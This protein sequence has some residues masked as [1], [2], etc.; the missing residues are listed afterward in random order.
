[1][2]LIAENVSALAAKL[3]TEPDIITKFL[4]NAEAAADIKPF[5]DSLGTLQVFTPD[6]FTQRLA[7]ERQAAATEATNTTLGKTYGAVDKRV[8]DATGIDKNQGESTLDYQERAFREKFSK[9]TDS[10]ENQR[11]RDDAKAARELLAAKTTEFETF[12]S[13]VE[14][15][16][17]KQRV[18]AAFTGAVGKLELTDPSQADFLQFKFEQQYT[19]K[20]NGEVVEYVNKATGEVERDPNTAGPIGAEALLK[21]FA[22][23]VA[24]VSFK[25]PSTRQPSGF[26]AGSPITITE[27]GVT[28]DYASLASYD[29]FKAHLA[30]QGIPAGSETAGKLYEGLKKARPDLLP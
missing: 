17:A 21:K 27:G 4:T 20:L 2:D 26:K 5:A 19:P 22:P 8:K 25:Q 30:K 11:L 24:G 9:T 13:G 6:I 23:T 28:M 14:K 1:M 12:K 29:E 7:N 3:G 18:A 15:Q 16:T 10:D